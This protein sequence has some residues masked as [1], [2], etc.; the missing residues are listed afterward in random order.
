M[1]ATSATIRAL[2]KSALPR[3]KGLFK[4][5]RLYN[6]DR[7]PERI[8]IGVV[9]RVYA[10]TSGLCPDAEFKKWITDFAMFEKGLS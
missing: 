7:T 6:W 5:D 10:E 2:V 3:T 8:L 9:A 1:P 4:L